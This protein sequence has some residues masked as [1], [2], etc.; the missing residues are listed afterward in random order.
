MAPSILTTSPIVE[1]PVRAD[2]PIKAQ[3]IIS[4]T[5]KLSQDERLTE[6]DPSKHLAYKE[7]SS[8]IMMRDLG[9]P[10]GVGVS[11]VAVCQPFQL[12][13]QDAIERMR[14]EILAPEVMQ[15]CQF[16]STLAACQLR[17]Y[18]NK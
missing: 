13:S 7:P 14:E 6:F 1:S 16:S 15:N 8:V 2:S 12:F 5:R 9:L 17:G 10:E 18:A 4:S 3:P 11:P